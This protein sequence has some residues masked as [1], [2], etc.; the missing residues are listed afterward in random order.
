MLL[1][2]LKPLKAQRTGPAIP[3]TQA[4]IIANLEVG[5]F[6]ILKIK[7]FSDIILMISLNVYS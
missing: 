2:I 7:I 1:V 5:F 4:P 6:A 3:A